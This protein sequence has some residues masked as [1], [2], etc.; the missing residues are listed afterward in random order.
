MSLQQDHDFEVLLEYLRQSRGF[1]FTGYKRSTLARRV[2]KRA[3]QLNSQ[4]FADYLDYIQVHPDEFETL[5]NT[6]LINVTEFFRD[7][8]AWDVL[9]KEAVPRILSKDESQPIRVWSAGCASGEEAYS[10]AILLCEALGAEQFGKRVKIYATDVDEEALATARTGYSL[11][12]LGSVG[13]DLIPKYFESQGGRYVFRTSLRRAVIFGRHD[14]IQDA[15]ISRLDLLVC[16]NTLMYFTAESQGRVL[17]NFHYALNDAGYLFAGRAEMLLTHADLFTPLDMKH[18]IFTKVPRVP[19]GD[20]V[21]PAQLG[22]VD[23]GNTAIHKARLREI[24]SDL[25]AVPQLLLDSQGVL[26]AVNKP[27]QAQLGVSQKD[28]GRPLR[29]LDLSYKPLELRSQID[30]SSQQRQRVEVD[31][32]EWP[33]AD[34]SVRYY[35][36]RVEPLVEE[37]GDLA[38]TSITFRDVTEAERLRKELERSNQEKETAYEELQSANEE[39]ETTNEELQSTIEELETTNEELQSSNEEMETMNEEL[40]S[41]NSE[42]QAIN[43]DLRVRTD[44]VDRL[45]TFLDSI[46]TSLKAGVA[47]LDKDFRVLIWNARLQ[48]LWGLRPEEALSQDFFELDLGLPLDLLRQKVLRVVRGEAPNLVDVVNATNRRGKLIRCQVSATRLASIDGAGVGVVLVMEEVDDK[49]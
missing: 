28:I 27:A 12:A 46:L 24:A 19:V 42:L 37:D 29:D 1:D 13:E 35:Q 38:G 15:P 30:R 5:F 31:R 20:R 34:G 6:I 8:A 4:S 17:T 16:R 48:D 21:P 40:E 33:Q 32:V 9:A 22:N 14:L 44:E 36:V 43:S 23:L 18:R 47:V 39:L 25:P 2:G 7:K 11:E 3:H 26:V 49:A 45:N 10:I 41:T